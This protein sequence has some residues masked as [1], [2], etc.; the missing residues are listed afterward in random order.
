M[1][2]PRNATAFQGSRTYSHDGEKYL[3]VTTYLQSW[4]KPWLGAWAA[5]MVAEGAVLDKGW[6]GQYPDP[7]DAIKYLKGIPWRKRDTAADFGSA[8]HAALAQLVAGQSVDTPAGAERHVEALVAWWDTYRPLALDSEVQV[9]N[10]AERYAGSLD[11][12][13]EVYGR[14]YLVDLK[15]GNSLGAEIPLQLAA[16]RYAESIFEDDRIIASVPIVDACAVLWIPRDTPDEW[17]FLEVPA[18]GAEYAAF[19]N[20]KAT[21]TYVKE[22]EKDGGIGYLILP[23]EVR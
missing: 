7:L 6:I 11:L 3:S 17:Q 21:H 9:V 13:C 15:T 18:G 1:T 10:L 23:Q 16:Y 4:P 5:K 8:V 2:S 20:L 22:R 12:I 14:R 19:L